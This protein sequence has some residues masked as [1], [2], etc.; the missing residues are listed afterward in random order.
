MKT[1]LTFYPNKTKQN[2][3]TGKVPLYARVCS[4]GQKA[5]ERLNADVPEKELV[6]WDP[7]SMRFSDRTF[8][9]NKILNVL[10]RRFEEFLIMNTTSLDKFQPRAILDYVLGKEVNKKKEVTVIDYMESYFTKTVQ[11]NTELSPGT[12]RN[13]RK[14]INHFTSFLQVNQKRPSPSVA[15]IILLPSGSKNTY[16]TVMAAVNGPA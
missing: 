12:V 2:K 11:R 9:A 16:K 14:S 3:K 4:K 8:A 1:S 7:M 13:Y 5:E 10:D 6:K 15:W